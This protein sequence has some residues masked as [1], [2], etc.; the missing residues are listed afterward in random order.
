MYLLKLVELQ[1]PV[2]VDKCYSLLVFIDHVSE[3]G[4]NKARDRAEF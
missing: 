4:K 1:V 2:I 3:L